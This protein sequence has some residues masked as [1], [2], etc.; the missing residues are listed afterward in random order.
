MEKENCGWSFVAF[1][2]GKESKSAL[3]AFDCLTEIIFRKGEPPGETEC[4]DVQ[5]LL[6]LWIVWQLSHYNAPQRVDSHPTN[7]EC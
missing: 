7:Y 6:A 1:V 3:P 4:E 2:V 5:R